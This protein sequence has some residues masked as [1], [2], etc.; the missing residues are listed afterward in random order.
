MTEQ[1]NLSKRVNKTNIILERGNITQQAVDAIVNAAN[2][3]LLGGGGVDGAI[4]RAG[5]PTILAECQQIR[6]RQGGCKP[7]N[8]VITSAGNLN[9]KHVVHTVGP[10]WHGGDNGEP[11]I[12]A[13]AYRTSLVLAAEAGDKTIAFPSISTGA[14]GYPIKEAAAVAVDT[15]VNYAKWQESFNEVRFVVFDD[16]AL[17]AFQIALAK[18][19]D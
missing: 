7:G 14:Y 1:A 6:D 18:V 13:S 16:A 12:L 15:V 8:A 11:E 19:A 4:H 5:G 17:T 2:S 9:A 3:S 10:V